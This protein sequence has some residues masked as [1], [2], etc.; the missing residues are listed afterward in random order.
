MGVIII[1]GAPG[2]G[3]TTVSR[4]LHEKLKSPWFEFGWIPEFA[5]LTPHTRITPKQ[6][7]QIAFENL[8]LVAKNYMRH[9]FTNIIFSDLQD[10]RMLDIPEAF[11]GHNY[12]MVTLFAEDNDVIKARTLGRD[13]GNDYRD[14]EQAIAINT[15][16]K[17]RRPLPNEYRICWD[18][19][20]VDE[21]VAQALHIL[22][23][24]KPAAACDLAQYNRDDYFTYFDENGSYI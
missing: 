22:Q 17:N 19:Q 1:H 5:N 3:K 2:C 9:G 16:I 11:A 21:I 20:S 12:V 15:Q 6:E 13:N 24:H 23:T 10:V 14:F 4:A 8:V 18:K 7:E